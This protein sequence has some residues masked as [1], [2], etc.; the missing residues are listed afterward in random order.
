VRPGAFLVAALA[1]GVAVA[2]CDSDEPPTA[3]GTAPSYEPSTAAGEALGH[4]HDLVGHVSLT[5]PAASA[6]APS[7]TPSA[8]PVAA[9]Q[10]KPDASALSRTPQAAASAV[11]CGDKPAP[12][13]PMAAWMK[14]NATPAIT[15]SNF[16]ALAA[17]LGRTVALAPEGYANWASISRDGAD[18]ARV[19]NLDA[20]KASCRS[21]H[22]QYRG[23]YRAEMRARPL[24]L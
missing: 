16:E 24:P 5:R 22:N 15:S 14:A 21:C 11:A 7:P 3:I 4:R 17:V 20:V 19:Q 18:A 8:A 2:A 10:E 13:C 6:S 12:A 9:V 1:V 23:R